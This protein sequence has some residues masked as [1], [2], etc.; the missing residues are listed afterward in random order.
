MGPPKEANLGEDNKEDVLKDPEDI[1]EKKNDE[2]QE[3][4]ASY[5]SNEEELMTIMILL[6]MFCFSYLSCK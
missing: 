1:E 3:N 4:G 2:K 6:K 5:V